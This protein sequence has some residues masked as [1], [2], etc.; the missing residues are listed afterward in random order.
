MLASY[1][2]SLFTKVG[3]DEP[4]VEHDTTSF[5]ASFDTTQLMWCQPYARWRQDLA[6]HPV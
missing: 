6:L 5:S 2:P 3:S 4:Q 1:T